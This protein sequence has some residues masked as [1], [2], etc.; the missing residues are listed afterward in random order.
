MSLQCIVV[1][2][3]GHLSPDLIG[4]NGVKQG[5]GLS[6][7]LSNIFQNDLHLIFSSNECDPVCLNTIVLNSI[8]WADDLIL[9]SR[10]QKGLQ[11]CLDKLHTY[12]RKWGLEVNMDNTKVMT[13]SKRG[14]VKQINYLGFIIKETGNFSALIKDRV[15]KASRATNLV[16]QAF[17]KTSNVNVKLS[18]GI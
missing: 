15:S 1:N 14:C 10:S 16:R 9:I 2:I 17:R 5:C 11:V 3:S 7:L 13:F 8:S 6:P 4:N 12:C 18:L